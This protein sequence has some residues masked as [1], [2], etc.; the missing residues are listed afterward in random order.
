MQRSWDLVLIV[1]FSLLL[2]A[3]IYFIP[4][5]P[6]RII[7]SIPFMIFFPGYS[8]ISTLFPE[9]KSIVTIERLALSFGLSIAVVSL[10][11]FG[12]NY[13]PFGIRLNPILWS[14][15]VFNSVL[16]IV[17]ASRRN[18]SS[19]PFI[20][21]SPGKILDRSKG[22]VHGKGKLEKVIAAIVVIAVLSSVLALA[23]AIA[24][25]K[26]GEHFTDFY[27]L[28]AGGSASNYP[29]NI[30]ANESATVFV[31]IANHEHHTV[32]Y[33]LDVW[34][35]NETFSD[36]ITVVSN[37]YYLDGYSIVL[38]HVPAATESNWTKEWQEPYTFSFPIAGSYK[39]WFVLQV[40]GVAFQGVKNQDYAGTPAQDR[41]IIMV[42]S[43]DY[44]SLNL[45]INITG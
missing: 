20:P 16:S 42:G 33:T 13:T 3:F 17:G 1:L 35:V 8:L 27:V 41:F 18:T 6:G 39:I 37:L 34:L 29:H 40:D 28:G 9:R 11:G 10:I 36:N 25:P 26:E 21:V 19:E 31:G 2:A 4:D 45:N 43:N 44:Y 7:I 30:T 22:I 38:D 5:S 15:I 14:L 32:N 12:L 23:Y 24:V